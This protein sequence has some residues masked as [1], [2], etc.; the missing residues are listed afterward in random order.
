[1]RGVL[2]REVGPIGWRHVA[3]SNAVGKD[4]ARLRSDLLIIGRRIDVI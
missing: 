2:R 3:I 4:A 1:M